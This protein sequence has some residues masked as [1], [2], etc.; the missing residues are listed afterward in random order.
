MMECAYKENG[1]CN[2]CA[3]CM[4]CPENTREYE[5]DFNSDSDDLAIFICNICG[6]EIETNK[7]DCEEDLWSH[8]QLGHAEIFEE[9]QNWETPY[10]MEVYFNEHKLT[11][12]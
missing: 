3:E 10:M 7:G 12:R 2:T 1:E 8:L 4:S 6:S 11:F 5:K 9:C